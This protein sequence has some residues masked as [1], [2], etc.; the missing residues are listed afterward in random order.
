MKKKFSSYCRMDQLLM[1]SF[2]G[3]TLELSFNPHQNKHSCTPNGVFRNTKT[4]ECRGQGKL[5]KVGAGQNTD[6]CPGA[7]SILKTI[8]YAA[9][10]KNRCFA[11]ETELIKIKSM[12]LLYSIK[13]F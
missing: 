9:D 3:R 4:K 12:F 13:F 8:L 11:L 6:F 5:Q 2:L 7:E 10:E 1:L